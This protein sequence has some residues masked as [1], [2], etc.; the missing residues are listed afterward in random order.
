MPDTATTVTNQVAVIDKQEFIATMQDA[1]VKEVMLGTLAENSIDITE[2]DQETSLSGVSLPVLG[3][4]GTLKTVPYSA[5]TTVVSNAETATTNA[6]NAAANANAA[7]D[8]ATS[9]ASTANT[10]AA[11]ANAAVAALSASV[12]NEV[13]TLNM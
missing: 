5:L 13:L 10:A 1:D 12:T 4:N 9:A 11:A 3:S 7:A 8:T 6:S 2:L